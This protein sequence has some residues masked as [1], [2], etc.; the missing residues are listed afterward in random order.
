MYVPAPSTEARKDPTRG[1]TRRGSAQDHVSRGHARLKTRRN[2]FCIGW[3]C[4]GFAACM[5]VQGAG[6][7]LQAVWFIDAAAQT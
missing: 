5:Q 2:G 6:Q 3:G 4:M 1:R 7:R